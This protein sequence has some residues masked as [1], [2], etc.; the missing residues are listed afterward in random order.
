MPGDKCLAGLAR[1]GGC[2]DEVKNSCRFTPR[3]LLKDNWGWCTGE[4]RQQYTGQS[5]TYG[6]IGTEEIP[7]VNGGCYDFSKDVVNYD[8]DNNNSLDDEIF[9]NPALANEC[10]PDNA[11]SARPWIVYNG[12]LQLGI[13]Q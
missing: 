3:V 10:N 5:L 4:C 6:P 2:F 11:G 8:V 9:D 12:A 7:H 1:P 13:T